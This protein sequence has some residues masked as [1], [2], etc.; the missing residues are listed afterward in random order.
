MSKLSVSPLAVIV[1]FS[2]FTS[3][4]VLGSLVTASN[5]F[6]RNLSLTVTGNKKLLSELFLKISA[7][8]L[9]ATTSNPA[10]LIAHAACSR[11]EPQP[12]FLPATK[13]LPL[14]FLLFKGKSSFGWVSSSLIYL[15]SRN[16]FL[17]NPSRLVAFKKRAGMIW[18][19]ST[20]SIFS[21]TAVDLTMFM[22]LAML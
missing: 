5:N 22:L 8:K 6:D 18:S 10:S 21:G 17:P 14:Y 19:V 7:K 13:I 1:C 3:I 15:Q 16:R 4:S 20:F 11:E 2:R 9:L 12:K